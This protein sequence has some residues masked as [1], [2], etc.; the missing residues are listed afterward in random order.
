MDNEEVF[1]NVSL[2][3]VGSFESSSSQGTLPDGVDDPFIAWAISAVD[4]KIMRFAQT[5]GDVDP[6][7]IFA[8]EPELSREFALASDGEEAILGLQPESLV[9]LSAVVWTEARISRGADHTWLRLLAEPYVIE[10]HHPSGGK[11][12]Q[13]GGLMPLELMIPVLRTSL[14]Y[15]PSH[16]EYLSIR[17]VAIASNG[18]LS[19][20]G[21]LARRRIPFLKD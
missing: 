7:I 5:G 16:A 11:L 15:F 12:I 20:I 2:A 10:V 3:A 19:A 9:A 13:A 21:S 8:A 17:K 14:K 4:E 18:A 6:R 1:T